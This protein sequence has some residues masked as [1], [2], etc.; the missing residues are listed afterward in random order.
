[1]GW[2]SEIVK[3]AVHD[4]F[5][6]QVRS[7]WFKE[8]V[9]EIRDTSLATGD[10]NLIPRGKLMFEQSMVAYAVRIHGMAEDHA[11]NMLQGWERD[12]GAKYGDKD[13][14]WSLAGARTLV[15]EWMRA[16]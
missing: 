7:G 5:R 4:E 11:R 12:L 15:D 9:Q 6:A 13:Y 1:M 8:L 3:E 2:I 10:P 16:D 14:D